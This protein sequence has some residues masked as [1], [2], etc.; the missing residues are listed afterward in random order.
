MVKDQQVSLIR[1]LWLDPKMYKEDQEWVS[2]L[3][4]VSVTGSTMLDFEKRRKISWLLFFIPEV[5]SDK[6]IDLYVD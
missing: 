1:A 5:R 2:F 3:C 4:C 6:G